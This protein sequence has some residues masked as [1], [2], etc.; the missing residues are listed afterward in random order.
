MNARY[1]PCLAV[2]WFL[3]PVCV[4]IDIGGIGDLES[5]TCRARLSLETSRIATLRAPAFSA[6]GLQTN[7]TF[8][9]RRAD[10]EAAVPESF[11]RVSGADTCP[12][13]TALVPDGDHYN[14]STRQG[15]SC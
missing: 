1:W 7:C 9:R 6:G 11:T 13:I 10:S 15:A 5:C 12:G 4:D 3:S 14:C 2:I 8:G